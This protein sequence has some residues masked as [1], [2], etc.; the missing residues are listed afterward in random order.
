MRI[1]AAAAS[2]Y[3]RPFVYLKDEQSNIW[4]FSDYEN[5]FPLPTVQS[6]LGFATGCPSVHPMSW[7]IYNVSYRDL[8]RQFG[9]GRKLT[10]TSFQKAVYKSSRIRCAT[11]IC[12]WDN[13]LAFT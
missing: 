12:I 13:L 10:L 3:L 6:V 1:K 5:A 7:Q 11:Y 9:T 4:D 2:S 8:I